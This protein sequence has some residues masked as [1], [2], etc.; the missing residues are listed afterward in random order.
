VHS[1]MERLVA[2]AG[3][4]SSILLFGHGAWEKANTRAHGRADGNAEVKNFTGLKK[5]ALA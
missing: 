2:L 5:F 4:L 1:G 3:I